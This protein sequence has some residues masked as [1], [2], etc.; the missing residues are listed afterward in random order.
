MTPAEARAAGGYVL[1]WMRVAV[2]AHE[3]PALDVAVALARAWGL[4][5]LVL[6]ALGERYPF[7]SDR[8]H[9]FILEGAL[10]VRE[11]LAAKGIA[12]VFHLERPGHRGPHLRTLASRAA[13]VVTELTPME[14]LRGWTRRLAEVAPLVEVDASCI[15]PLPST[16]GAA[17]T[18][19]FAFRDATAALAA[20]TLSGAYPVEPASGEGIREVS[21][22]AFALPMQPLTFARADI[23]ALVG[24]ADIDHG[25]APVPSSR[26][27]TRAGYARWEAFVGTQ[28]SAYA[29]TRNDPLLEGT[30]RMSPYLHY[31]HVSPFRLGRDA[32]ARKGSQGAAK[33][34]DELLVWRE[35]AWHFCFHEEHH[36]TVR[37]LPLWARETLRAHQPDPR[38][39]LPSW[40][41]LARGRSGDV[42]WDLAQQSLRAHGELHNNLRMTWGKALVGWTE[43]AEDA[44]GLLVDLNHRYALDGRD[45]GSYGG[46]L[47]CLGAFDRPFPPER[48]VLGTVRER[49]TTQHAARLDVAAYRA[50]VRRSPFHHPPRVAVVGAGLSGIAAART[51]LDHN[52]HTTLLDRAERPGGR[53]TSRTLAGV[54]FDYGAQY[55]TARSG[56]F[57]HLAAALAWEGELAR[58]SPRVAHLGGAAAAAAPP[59]VEPP[60]YVAPGGFSRFTARLCEGLGARLGT[61]VDR[62]VEQP[63]GGFRLEGTGLDAD[64]TFDTVLLAVPMPNAAALMPADAFVESVASRVHYAPCWSVTFA[65]EPREW[66]FDAAIVADGALS[67]ACRETSKPGRSAALDVWTLHAS[68]AFS[69]AHLDAPPAE[70]AKLLHGAFAAWVELPCALLGEPHCKQWR[71][72]RPARGAKGSPRYAFD[73]PRGLGIAGD[74]LGGPR[75]EGAYASGVALAGHVLRNLARL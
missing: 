44:L 20:A 14:P 67:W 16:L 53:L 75:V 63:G 1:Y 57:A 23:S 61:R 7:A 66:P 42:L 17:P 12:Y 51:L 29:A 28:L 56:D 31:G 30:S 52:V 11:D 38:R 58:W 32:F 43:T 73:E 13:T 68:T 41:S 65:T 18:R 22:D 26:G 34:L 59:E 70:V 45:P 3:N 36:D 19:A 64:A 4:P 48:P 60:W 9:T 54:A 71:L 25:V 8:H 33:F 27:G 69:E 10:D 15:V 21:L 49:S 24:S 40:E 6:H 46:I 62:V 74:G 39:H 2:R 50:H 35:L 47:W 72:A 55:F 37:A 5:L